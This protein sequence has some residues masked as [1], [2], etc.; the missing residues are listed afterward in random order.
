MTPAEK[1]IITIE[2]YFGKY[3]TETIKIEVIRFLEEY[4]PEDYSLL[5][6]L[7][8]KN[9]PTTYQVPPD[10]YA[11]NK[12]IE[13]C[14]DDFKNDLSWQKVRTL[15]EVRRDQKAIESPKTDGLKE[16]YKNLYC[17]ACKSEAWYEAATNSYRC[18]KCNYDY[19]VTAKEYFK[20]KGLIKND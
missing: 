16:Q 5:F 9:Y 12:V 14:A 2:N 8:K 7:L 15:E 19:N 20:Q 13:K 18:F 10:V 6:E 4:Y 1:Y 3:K 11:I 17:P